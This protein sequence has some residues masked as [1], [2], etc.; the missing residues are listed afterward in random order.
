ML[1]FQNDRVIAV[2]L[3]DDD[4]LRTVQSFP[5]T[6]EESCLIFTRMK[7]DL[8]LKTAHKEGLIRPTILYQCLAYLKENHRGYSNINI[9]E[10]KEWLEGGFLKEV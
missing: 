9:V 10:M 6:C 5:R 8:S 7:R 1:Q 2:V 4:L 3:G